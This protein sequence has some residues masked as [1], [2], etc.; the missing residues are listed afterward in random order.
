[1]KVSVSPRTDRLVCFSHLRWNFVFQRPQHLLTRAAKEHPVFFVEEPLYEDGRS[2]P[3]VDISEHPSGV[4]VVTPVLAAGTSTSDAI[5]FQKSMVDQLLG[6]DGA[7]RTTFWYYTPMALTFTA[8]HEPDV[9]VYDCMDELSAF[10]GAPPELTRLERLLMEKADVMFT[11]GRSLYEAKRGKHPNVHAFPSS[12]DA[13]HF[14]Q[15]RR[16]AKGEPA[17]QAGLARPRIGFFGVVD[18]R[19]DT[20]L[21][22][23]AARLR[24]DWQ[25]VVVG[26]VVKIDPADLP[27]ADNLA[28]LGSKSYQELPAYLAGWDAGF[29]PFALNEATRFISPTKTPEFLAAGVPVV[30]TAIRDVVTPYGDNGLVEIVHTPEETVAAL[31]AV[32]AR[33][34]DEWLRQVDRFLADMSWDRTWSQM[35]ALMRTPAPSGA[36]TNPLVEDDAERGIAR[37]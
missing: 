20:A 10:R 11:G 12:I 9:C 31:D 18:E 28:W 23:A 7:A 16:W 17:D 3:R 27:K 5:R 4:T 2:K 21:V 22:A 32:M 6:P 29:M 35:A 33:P 19:M 30:S 25:F 24:P 26:P 15:A 8:H 37:A 36:A 34:R 14:R 13:P 1:M